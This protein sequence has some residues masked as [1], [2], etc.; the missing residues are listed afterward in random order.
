MLSISESYGVGEGGGYDCPHFLKRLILF[1]PVKLWK[2][3]LFCIYVYIFYM[4][5]DGDD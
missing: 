4:F 2:H 1:K 3:R 5:E